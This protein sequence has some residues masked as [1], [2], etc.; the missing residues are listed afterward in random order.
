M[1]RISFVIVA[2]L[3][4][5]LVLVSTAN[6][7]RRATVR[8]V[9]LLA[10]ATANYSREDTL[11]LDAQG[12]LY[13]ADPS[14]P[15]RFRDQAY[16]ISSIGP[17]WARVAV[18]TTRNERIST[19]L[20]RRNGRWRALSSGSNVADFRI[21]RDGTLCR[22][23]GIPPLA[24]IDLLLGRYGVDD[25]RREC[26][27]RDAA[28]RRRMTGDQVTALEGVVTNGDVPNHEDIG[29]CSITYPGTNVIPLEG[30]QSV[31]APNWSAV[32]VWCTAF[33]DGFGGV[34]GEF[35]AILRDGQA[36][37]RIR[38]SETRGSERCTAAGVLGTVPIRARLELR[39]CVDHDRRFSQI[40]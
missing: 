31:G 12:R 23:S 32:T 5:S 18:L 37:E 40:A 38:I 39:L 20:Q 1:R 21:G 9:R 22:Q 35:R 2:T 4:V 3:L 7:A 29:E 14:F 15:R 13:E 36:I 6:A 34:L 24:A 28:L 26:E 17:S 10:A 19:V 8:E 27:G 30:W 16:M 25:A 33:T 11:G